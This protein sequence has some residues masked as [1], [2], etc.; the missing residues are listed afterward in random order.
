MIGAD[1]QT[2]P[3]AI[4]R[5]PATSANVGVGFDCLGIALDLTATFLMTPSDELVIEGC[6]ERFRGEANLVWQSYLTACGELD[7]EPQ[8]LRITILSPIPLSGGLGSSSTCVIAGVAAAQILGLGAYDA[9]Q[10]LVLSTRIEGHPDNVAPAIMGGLVSSF[11][12]GDQTT[13][14]R[15]DIA[16]NLR[17]VAIAPPYEVRTADARRVLPTEVPAS[18]AVWQMGRCV[19]VVR[20]LELGDAELL[21]KA[22]NDKLHEPYRSKLIPDYEPLK[23]CALEAGACAFMISGSG[24]TMLAVAD[25]EKT[26]AA[27]EA[28]LRDARPDFWV[29][30]LPANSLGTTVELN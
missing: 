17:F 1:G 22:N 9:E 24:S 14:T 25:G 15:M 21:S 6:E 29:R 27:V 11:V 20:A 16:D 2:C 23:A 12:D 3:I 19:A 28:A 7:V 5:V 8:K 18:T 26:A 4:V 13:S 10:C 30:N